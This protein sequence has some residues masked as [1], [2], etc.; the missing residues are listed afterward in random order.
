MNR[1]LW[2][3]SFIII[4]GA[5]VTVL[6]IIKFYHQFEILR[7][8]SFSSEI[9]YHNRSN[10]QKV[11][12]MLRTLPFKKRTPRSK[13]T[14]LA[15]S[16]KPH[17]LLIENVP[18]TPRRGPQ[19]V[20]LVVSVVIDFSSNKWALKYRDQKAI[21]KEAIINC[22]QRLDY[23]DLRSSEGPLL[24]KNVLERDLQKVLKDK[25]TDLWITKYDFQCIKGQ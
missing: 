17:Q 7:L 3:V 24:L 10:R 13:S 16:L 25:V 22:V 1:K 20:Y 18:S 6:L 21:L 11:P 19:G 14:L 5:L 15:R 12:S 8:R 2:I 9:R 23:R 4:I